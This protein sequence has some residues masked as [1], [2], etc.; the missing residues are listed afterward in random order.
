MCHFTCSK[1]HETTNLTGTQT[2]LYV[3]FVEQSVLC[4]QVT[5]TPTRN[6]VWSGCVVLKLDHSSLFFFF[7]LT[8]HNCE[9]PRKWDNL[10]STSLPCLWLKRL[11]LC[12]ILGAATIVSRCCTIFSLF[13]PDWVE[14]FLFLF[15]KYRIPACMKMQDYLTI[16]WTQISDSELSFRAGSM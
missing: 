16:T 10:I 4:F 8:R 11:K 6:I 13:C 2:S 15:L 9:T 5:L 3:Q 12:L 1:Y 14:V 7:I